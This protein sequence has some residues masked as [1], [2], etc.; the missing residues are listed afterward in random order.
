MNGKRIARVIYMA[1]AILAVIAGLSCTTLSVDTYAANPKTE[2]KQA[3]KQLMK[4]IKNCNDKDIN[5]TI[6][7]KG[8]HN[9]FK[10]A[11]KNNPG[12][13]IYVKKANK[14][15]S[16]KITKVKVDG[17]KA[18]VKVKIRYVDATETVKNAIKEF[19]AAEA[20]GEFKIPSQE[21]L[22]AMDFDETWDLAMKLI[23]KLDEC[24]GRAASYSSMKKMRTETVTL[25]MV[26]VGKR[27]KL[28]LLESNMHNI[29]FA[30]YP[31]A[32]KAISEEETK[33]LRAEGAAS[34]KTETPAETSAE[35]P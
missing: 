9:W 20:R 10:Y 24:V 2:V 6:R 21:E 1:V 23:A 12:R 3:V 33:R 25:D 5:A 34:V 29:L 16:Y 19:G 35:T 31:R 7:P 30:D 14:K 26:K 11:K 4:G 28:D 22:D 8:Q 13:C 32:E 18:T 17:K 27:W 15:L